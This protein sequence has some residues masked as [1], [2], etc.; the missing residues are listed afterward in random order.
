[1]SCQSLTAKISSDVILEIQALKIQGKTYVEIHDALGVSPAT[2]CRYLKQANLAKDKP[3]KWKKP[4]DLSIRKLDDDVIEIDNCQYKIGSHGYIFTK[5]LGAWV[6]SS[7][8]L[9]TFNKHL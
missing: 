9:E 6:R 7:M 4:S 8:T 5:H 3:D 2:I 1:M